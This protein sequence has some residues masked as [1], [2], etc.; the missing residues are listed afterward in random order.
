MF[1]CCHGSGRKERKNKERHFLQACTK[2]VILTEDKGENFPTCSCGWTCFVIRVSYYQVL[3]TKKSL[4]VT[5]AENK[6]I[7]TRM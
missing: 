2:V 1:L 7:V 5:D 3:V 6:L 4:R